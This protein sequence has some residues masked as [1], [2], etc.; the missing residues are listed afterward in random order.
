MFYWLF[1]NQNIPNPSLVLWLNGGPGSSSMFGLFMENGPLRV[2]R[3]GPG[4]GDLVIG[5]PKSGGSW[6]DEADILFLD[7]P[8][9]TGFSYGDSFSTSMDMISQ[10][11]LTFL[12]SFIFEQYPEYATRDF[13][14]TGESY[15]GKY[16]PQLATTI[17][18]YNL[19]QSSLPEGSQ[20][21]IQ[22]KAALIGD[23]FV[24]PVRQRMATYLIAKDTGILDEVHLRQVA[25]M[26]R[27]CENTISTMWN[28]TD[29]VCNDVL[30]YISEMSGGVVTY[31]ATIF[32]PDLDEA[33]S[34]YGDYLST[35]NPQ[36]QA[37]YKAL[38]I[39]ASTK[40][41]IF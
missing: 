3:I 19:Q 31:D 15:A 9:N 1:K 41:P 6:S 20:K 24:S 8:V 16:L 22:L 32:N 29:N 27:R 30:E 40:N 38:H 14:I 25:A 18:K 7:Q 34:P 21:A 36:S 33:E 5:L 2:E 10:E 39:D 37:V 11:M 13:L 4:P 12:T 23:P 26:K 35:K 28:K 17:H